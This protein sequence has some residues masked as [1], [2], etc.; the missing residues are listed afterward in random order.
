MRSKILTAV[1]RPKDDAALFA[2]QN[3]VIQNKIIGVTMPNR[4]ANVILNID[5]VLGKA[6]AHP[7]AEKDADIISL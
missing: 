5:V 7:P 4:N 2:A 3:I 1:V 6:V